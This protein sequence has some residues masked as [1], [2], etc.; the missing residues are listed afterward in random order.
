M[1]TTARVYAFVLECPDPE[2]LAKFY[3]ELTGWQVMSSDPDWASIRETAE[4][5][6]RL[7]FQAAPGYQAP[8]WPD[9]ASPMQ[10]HIDFMVEN[11]DDAEQA[12]LALGATKFEHQPGDD[13][14]VYAD[15]VGHP[16]CLCW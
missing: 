10:Y 3:S 9:P 6:V 5:G 16:F 2:A 13:F 11:I 12:A 8:G 15:P 14:R 4:A 1:A 7:S